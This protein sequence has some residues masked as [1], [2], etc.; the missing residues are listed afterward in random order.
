[1]CVCGRKYHHWTGAG[2]DSHDCRKFCENDGTISWKS[3]HSVMELSLC[4]VSIIHLLQI[5]WNNGVNVGTSH[6]VIITALLMIKL[7]PNIDNT[8]LMELGYRHPPDH[9]THWLLTSIDNNI[10]I[11][12][13]LGWYYQSYIIYCF[14]KND[15]N[16]TSIG[17]NTLSLECIKIAI[18]LLIINSAIA[19]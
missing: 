18:L 13:Y 15:Y 7:L 9:Q 3:L 2:W 8:F 17:N 10:Y 12:T 11:F 5:S 14:L 4:I 16:T 6:H 19:T 1:M